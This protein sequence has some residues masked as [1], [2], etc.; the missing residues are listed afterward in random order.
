MAK[1]IRKRK[2]LDKV[3]DLPQEETVPEEASSLSARERT[4]FMAELSHKL[5]LDGDLVLILDPS[6]LGYKDLSDGA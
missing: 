2:G 5:D 1:K 4:A 3:L 6:S